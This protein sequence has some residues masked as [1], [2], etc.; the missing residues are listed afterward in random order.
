MF[1]RKDNTLVEILDR[2]K[3]IEG[4]VDQIPTGASIPAGFGLLQT[5]PYSQL[6]LGPNIDP[7]AIYAASSVQFSKQLSSGS[8]GPNRSYQDTFAANKMLTWPAVQQL[9]QQATLSSLGV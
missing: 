8:N 6:S 9:L 3:N 2:L 5:S 7:P 1:S 4:K